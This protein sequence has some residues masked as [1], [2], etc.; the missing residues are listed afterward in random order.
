MPFTLFTSNRLEVL[1][2]K[3]ID[4]F[5]QPL[6]SP[7]PQEIVVVQS[8]GMQRW[9]SLNIAGE[10]GI[11]ANVRFPFPNGFVREIV[12]HVFAS[13]TPEL[14]S[15]QT[16]V[17]GNGLESG[18]VLPDR[19]VYEPEVMTWRI[20]NL[21]PQ[22][23][24]QKAFKQLKSYLE[25]ADYNLKWLQLCVRIADLFDQYLLFRPEMI[26]KWEKGDENHWQA[27]L[28]R[29]LSLGIKE[30]HRAAMGKQVVQMLESAQPGTFS[31]P[32]RIAVF[33][34]SALPVF[35]L[36]VL[37]ALSGICQVNLFLMNP[38][39]EFWA[40]IK[41]EKEI[42]KA[43]EKSAQIPIDFS[44]EEQHFEAGNSLLA[45]MGKLGRDFISLIEDIDYHQEEH[46]RESSEE[47]LL[48]ALQSDILNMRDFV[49]ANGKKRVV[50]DSDFSIQFHAC[51]SER[52]E[53]EVLHDNLLNL[54][55]N[56][57]GLNPSEIL[58]M[59]PDIEPY[60]PFIQAVF[61]LPHGDPKRIPFSVADRSFGRESDIVETFFA[62]LNLCG[63]RFDAPSVMTILESTPV[64]SQFALDETDLELIQFWVSDSRIRWG[65]DAHQRANLGLPALPQN[66]WQAG[67]ERMLLGYA[68][69]VQGEQLFHDRILPYDK[70]E[71]GQA[72]VLGDFLE[73]LEKLFYWTNSLK[74]ARPLKEWGR[75]LTELL[76]VFFKASEEYERH[77]QA[78]RDALAELMTC[79]E[80]SAFNAAIN[81]DVIKRHL[82]NAMRTKGSGF[83]F[84]TGG[85]TFCSMLPMRSIPAKVICLIGM[86]YDA[87]PRTNKPLGFDLIAQ[88]PRKGDRSR[89]LDDRYLFLEAILSARD[90]LYIS[91]LGQSMK[92]NSVIPPSVLVS[93]LQENIQ[94][95]FAL[96]DNRDILEHFTVTHKLQA[97][98]P[99]YFYGDETANET[100]GYFSYSEDNLRVAKKL[101]TGNDAPPAFFN[102]PLPDPGEE[103]FTVTVDDLYKFFKNPVE[104]FL[105]RRLGVG[106]YADEEILEDA[107]IF[108]LSGLDRYSIA[109]AILSKESDTIDLE[110]FR[111]ANFAA[112]KLPLGAVGECEYGSLVEKVKHFSEQTN[113][114]KQS[115]KL[116]DLTVHLT[117]GDFTMTGKIKNIYGDG[118]VFA[119]YAR[120]KAKDYL[121]AWV[122]HLVFNCLGTDGYPAKSFLVGV[123]KP[124]DGLWTAW[125]FSPV[126][127]CYVCLQQLLEIYR[128]GLCAPIRF[129]PDS[130]LQ[131]LLALKK[132]PD[133]EAA[134]LSAAAKEWFTSNEQPFKESGD[135]YF[136][137][138]FGREENPFTEEFKVLAR[139]I[140]APLLENRSEAGE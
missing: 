3:L 105:N 66:T 61:D 81:L 7:L 48:L 37:N 72:E 73:F 117:L 42:S 111:K 75:T 131:F 76:A 95:N 119:R 114:F 4:T 22:L 54:F 10:L 138:C 123:N 51:H 56:V 57:P 127:N 34:I 62:I 130:A 112:G 82:E 107:E 84:L 18:F 139:Q 108:K 44:R 41:T 35:H 96:Q 85:V 53:I 100:P 120:L 24:E 132:K 1:S 13:S 28:W 50:K 55:E 124:A 94:Q 93:E 21:L 86:N 16:K 77:L 113:Q 27:Q 118:L 121:K 25:G 52:R 80:L 29:K 40:H 49:Q 19:S 79:Q 128:Q 9:L 104:F 70:I 63:S 11:C 87:Y 140:Y 32:Q 129:F 69:P 26:F 71:G 103:F 68:L 102:Q 60:A 116:P 83:G 135:P 64:L 38:C 46:F 43:V 36:H 133:D 67:V 17:S 74:T 23:L 5:R 58:V 89:R 115:N 91:Y 126:Q 122:Y 109:D 12:K 98:N 39:R 31:L 97:F 137:R 92:D 106:F 14:E 6:A 88:H 110:S 45:S 20:M 15:V 30:P 136:N 78:I 59:A 101:F 33:G 125:K 8:R 99:V 134:A 47:S 90:V 2:H 65:I